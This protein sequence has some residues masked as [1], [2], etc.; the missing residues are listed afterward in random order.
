MA[1]IYAGTSGWAYA[2]WKPKFYPAKLA[3]A[4]FLEYYATRLNTVEVNYTFRHY[5]SEKTLTNWVAATPAGFR[6]SIKAHQRITHIKRLRD[7]AEETKGFL[8]SLEPLSH[9][10]KLGMVLFQLP[11]YLKA[12]AAL[13]GGFL[14]GLPRAWRFAF[15][16][17]HES[18][19]AENIFEILRAHGAA[20]CVAES[21]KLESP[22]IATADFCYYR[23]RK[24]EYSLKERKE[25]AARVGKHLKEKRDVFVYFKH[26]E[27]PEGALYAAEL[28]AALGGNVSV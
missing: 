25:I 3:S 24:E 9:A 5:A 4:K 14:D 19:F 6:F 17:R 18:W 11:P 16:F 13:L 1:Q 12:D 10:G 28:V 2:A 8:G 7:A 15:E 20:L 21:E 23:L 27:T 26:E 22:D